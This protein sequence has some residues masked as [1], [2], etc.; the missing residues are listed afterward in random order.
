MAIA[1]KCLGSRSR[2]TSCGGKNAEPAQQLFIHVK[3]PRKHRELRHRRAYFNGWNGW[4]WS[5]GDPQPQQ[6][7]P[8]P[9][10]Y[11]PSFGTTKE[12]VSGA[13][14]ESEGE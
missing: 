7:L 8:G 6:H 2:T 10:T 4:G 3:E 1:R 14:Q 13:V 5:H 11:E 12:V 9:Q